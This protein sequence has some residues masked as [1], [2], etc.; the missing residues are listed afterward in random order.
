MKIIQST[1]IAFLICFVSVCSAQ[2]ARLKRE[3]SR[4][5]QAVRK[6]IHAHA[7]D[8]RLIGIEENNE[9]GEL[10]YDVEMVRDGKERSFTVD[11]EGGLI[12]EEVFINELPQPVQQSIRKQAGTATLGE[13]D[14]SVDDG[15][16]SYDVEVTRGV[17]TSEFTVDG[18]GELLEEEVFL[19]E[20]PRA[21]QQTIQTQLGGATLGEIDK[22]V[23]DGE[24]LYDVEMTGAGA[25]RNF[26]VRGKG[27]LLDV[28]VFMPELP[29][30]VQSAIQK[31]T[32]GAQP[33]GIEKC[34][35]DGEVSYDVE[36]AT[37]GQT[38]IVSFDPDGELF[39]S[40]E[41]VELS[42]TPE[43]VQTQIKS[44]VSSGKLLGIGKITEDKEVS[45]EVGVKNGTVEK[46]VRLG[47]DGNVLPE[48]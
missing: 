41:D 38:R 47:P 8:G 48:D 33:D 30:A 20:L 31:Q 16:T 10:S 40:E 17:R 39:S 15:E 12:D 43:A 45:Y 24:T 36:L 46:T 5:P 34:F 18:D 23:E 21:V 11:G 44:L 6:A 2:Q 28:E 42:G 13:I 14:R 27:E 4:M 19:N 7:G 25:A 29:A 22:S 1:I 32:G 37:N 9:D 26:P 3:L 35:D